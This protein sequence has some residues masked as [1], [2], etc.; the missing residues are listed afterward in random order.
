MLKHSETNEDQPSQELKRMAFRIV[1]E[2]LANACRHSKNNQLFAELH[3]VGNT[4]RIK[5][6]D[7]GIGFEP[8]S[9][10]PGRFA[11]KRI[12]HRVKLLYGLATVHSVP[13]KGTSVIVELP[14][15]PGRGELKRK[16]GSKSCKV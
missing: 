5:I 3:L 4:L 16:L 12:H 1:Q 15:A 9:L 6:R 10:P 14:L 8:D 2:S 13:N 7:W 11:A